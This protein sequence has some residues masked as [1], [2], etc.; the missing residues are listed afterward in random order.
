MFRS[1]V[2]FLILAIFQPATAEYRVFTL[3]I[4]NQKTQ[5]NRQI[6]STL[7]PEQYIGLYPL[8]QDERISY[9]DTWM[10]KGRTD[11]L[12]SHCEKPLNLKADARQQLDR[13][14]A[15]STQLKPRS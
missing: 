12:R 7:D 2:F 10:C 8:S 4:E 13:S 11:F 3:L 6:E 1:L 9:V 14:P 15:D 5:V